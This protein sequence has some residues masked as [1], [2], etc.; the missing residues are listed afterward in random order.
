MR[1]IKNN[2][3]IE[4]IEY[5]NTKSG[6]FIK[7]SESGE[8]TAVVIAVGDGTKNNPISIEVG[9][10]IAYKPNVGTELSYEGK[11]YLLLNEKDVIAI[12]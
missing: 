11:D 8:L 4:A 2:I 1:P 7:A 9:Q 10:T 5:V 6:L 3:I 12:L